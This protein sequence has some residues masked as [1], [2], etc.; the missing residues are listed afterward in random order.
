MEGYLAEGNR[1]VSERIRTIRLEIE[2][3]TGALTR[4]LNRVAGPLLLWSARRE[5]LRFPQGRPLEPPTFLDRRNWP[6][7]LPA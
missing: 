7:P 1:A 6:K 2:R 4:L 5:A 3:E